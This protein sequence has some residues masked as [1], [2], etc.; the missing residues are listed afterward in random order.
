MPAKS[1]AL[2]SLIA[3]LLPMVF[4]LFASPP[5][6]VLKHDT[7]QD[8]RFI[9]G[10]FNTCY[11][12]VVVVAGISA[13]GHA[14]VGQATLALAMAAVAVFVLS[15]RRW[16]VSRM[17]LLGGVIAAGDVSAISRFRRLHIAGMLLN[18]VQLPLVAW[19]MT[20]LSAL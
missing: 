20:R 13:L 12:M 16:F 3:L 5:L 10:L 19:G 1:I 6:L 8:A 18:L 7:P 2:L 17:D 4:F 14:A 15:V 9:R 11:M